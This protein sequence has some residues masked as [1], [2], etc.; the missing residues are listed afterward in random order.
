MQYSREGPRFPVYIVRYAVR[1]RAERG[2]AGKYRKKE[3][4]HITP[5]DRVALPEVG[6]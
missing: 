5:R 6:L 1:Y 3:E 2:Y 4:K